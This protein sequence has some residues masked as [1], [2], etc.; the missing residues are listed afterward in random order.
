MIHAKVGRHLPSE[1][2]D[3]VTGHDTGEIGKEDESTGNRGCHC[4][5]SSIQRPSS[6][7]QTSC[8]NSQVEKLVIE[9]VLVL[10]IGH[11]LAS[12]HVNEGR[13]DHLYSHNI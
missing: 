7:D 8:R 9:A 3:L 4:Y 12:R 2:A 11:V 5:G 13:L 6:H 10:I 1:E